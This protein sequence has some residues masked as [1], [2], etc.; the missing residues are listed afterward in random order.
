MIAIITA[1]LISDPSFCVETRLDINGSGMQLCL[2]QAEIE[3]AKRYPSSHTI[4]I[5]CKL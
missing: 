2:K 1:C 3:A 4:K 5:R